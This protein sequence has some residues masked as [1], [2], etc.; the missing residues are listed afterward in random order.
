MK[1]SKEQRWQWQRLT[2]NQRRLLVSHRR[3]EL[4][5]EELDRRETL[6]DLELEFG[7]QQWDATVATLAE[8]DNDGERRGG[9]EDYEMTLGEIGFEMGL[10]SES[11][12][13]IQEKAF[14]KLRNSP[15]LR[16]LFFGDVGKRAT[17]TS[18]DLVNLALAAI[19]RAR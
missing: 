16:E 6:A 5:N 3:D 18:V 1:L 10:S 2:P 15:L 12:R 17:R 7:P 19:G 11:I 8:G 9:V 14:G 13:I 4:E